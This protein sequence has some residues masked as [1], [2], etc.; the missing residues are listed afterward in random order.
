MLAT[1]CVLERGFQ[2]APEKISAGK[3]LALQSQSQK[4]L[5]GLA[6]ERKIFKSVGLSWVTGRAHRDLSPAANLNN[7]QFL[8]KLQITASLSGLSLLLVSQL[9]LSPALQAFAKTPAKPLSM[10]AVAPSY[11][12]SVSRCDPNAGS[13]SG[14]GHNYPEPPNG[15]VGRS[16][17]MLKVKSQ[18]LQGNASR[19]GTAGSAES[20]PLLEGN[21][22]RET[23][24]DDAF[25]AAGIARTDAMQKKPRPAR[26]GEDVYRTWL[27]KTH[28]QFSLKAESLDPI[29]VLEVK[30][31]WDKADRTLKNLGI[32]HTTIGC[33]QLNRIGLSRA[34]VLVINC[35][36]A[37][38]RNSLQGIRDFV[39]RGGYLLTT[40]WA[41]QNMLGQTFP[42]YV[43][44][45]KGKSKG[46]VVDAQVVLPD[47]EF[48]Q[49]TV[50]N[51]SWKLD[52]E[53]QTV[54]VLKADVVKV[55]AVS[56][57][58]APLDPDR[59]GILAVAFSFGR[60]KVLHLVG[61]FDNNAL[62][63]FPRHLPDPAPLIGIGLR[64][65]LAANFIV[66]RLERGSN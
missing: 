3:V 59:Q 8:K 13:N 49:G 40:D 51:A 39:M 35:A 38:D 62:P 53:S 46:N 31:A 21:V 22:L 37:L 66:S 47:R 16:S 11:S 65:A 28:P 19:Q 26:V 18:A 36:G 6:W 17:M 15:P 56:R 29:E 4:R 54:R 25:A 57:D 43:E 12:D 60:G 24:P 50:N 5:H 1:H 34:K 48:F 45:N 7:L 33:G 42:G 23:T 27:S 41:L 2:P 52:E 63:F 20:K 58:L 10:P 61:H 44:W 64:Q 30:G 9:A 55:L 14:S 32:P